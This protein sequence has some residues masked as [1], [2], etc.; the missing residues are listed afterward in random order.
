MILLWCR[1]SVEI[2][3]SLVLIA[4][5]VLVYGVLPSAL[6]HAETKIFPLAT[7]SGRYDSNIFNRPAQFAPVGRQISD[8][9]S[10]VGGGVHLLHE[11][12]DLSADLTVGG[13]FNAYVENSDLNFFNVNLRG[14]LN[15]DRWV[16]QYVRG[17]RLRIT[18]SFRYTPESP[19]FLVG[20]RQVGPAE[21]DVFSRGIS[22]FRANTFLNTTSVNGSYPMSRDLTLDGG[23]TFAL[24]R[25]GRIY[26]GDVGGV[27]FFDTN[28]HTWF[29][30]PRYQL[31]RTDSVAAVYRQSFLSQ[32]PSDQP[33][34]TFNTNFVTLAGHYNKV[35]PEWTFSVEGGISLVEPASRTF[36]SGTIR[37]TTHPERTTVL[38][39][40]LSR[41]PKPSFY[42]EGGALISNLARVGISHRI[43]ERLTVEADAAYAYNEFIPHTEGTFKHLAATAGLSYKLTRT[44]T[45]NLL[46]AFHNIDT[47]RPDLSYQFSR[48]QVGF[49]LTAEWN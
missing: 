30:G 34:R 14:G 26:G 38:N 4:M 5:A 10:T 19:S 40:V 43:Y 46:Y 8:F 29:G 22:G 31:T 42:L 35:F 6:V 3:R 39:L 24:R 36:P 16:D 44:I 21:D 15:L 9:V 49:A 37:I 1:G 32:S 27:T 2:G 41:E 11:T 18:E 17:A 20:V 23:Y 13:S 47:D 45:G 25:V 48:H 33:S 7:A 12:R 28:S